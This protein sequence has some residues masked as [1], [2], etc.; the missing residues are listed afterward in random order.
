VQ[1]QLEHPSIVPVYDLGRDPSGRAFFAMRRIRGQA[2]DTILDKLRAGDEQALAEHGRHKLLAAFVR[3]CLAIDYAHS[4]GVVHR[5]LKPAN[6]M[7]GALGEVYVLDWGLAKVRSAHPPHDPPASV[8]GQGVVRAGPPATTEAGYALGTPAYMA[9]EQ[10]RGDTEAIGA[11]A[12]VYALG[13][14]LFEILTLEPLHGDGSAGALAIRAMKGVDARASVRAPHR[15]VPP[16]LE[17]A[18]VRATSLDPAAR[19]PSARALADDVEAYLN[20]DRDQQLR[21]EL[22]RAHLSRA[23]DAVAAL[24]TR[25]D[26]AVRRE[27]VREVGRGL[28][29][30]PDDHEALGLLGHLVPDVPRE[31]PPEVTAA[32]DEAVATPH[33]RIRRRVTALIVGGLSVVAPLYAL[34]GVRDLRL[35]LLPLA[36]WLFAAAHAWITVVRGRGRGSGWSQAVHLGRLRAGERR[37]HRPLRAVHPRARDGPG[38][39]DFVVVSVRKGHR[40]AIFVC[41]VLLAIVAPAVLVTAGVHPVV[42]AVDGDTLRI[43]TPALRLSGTATYALVTL[44]HLV[45]CFLASILAAA[46]RDV[47]TAAELRTQTLAWNLRHLVPTDAAPSSETR[48]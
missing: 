33:T 26:P 17:A 48:R 21:K 31:I 40:A 37:Q 28:A 10:A 41:V 7:L 34:S 39:R 47:A 12:D 14:I 44:G 16:E 15:D 3:V 35:A 23:R 27:A 6:V 38:G 20:G 1:G 8:S 42:H 43:Q 24:A 11:P 25:D 22:A 9:P 29:L 46:Y 5:D 45:V 32:V 30:A 36:A 18:C 2:L 4:R 13:A 19:H